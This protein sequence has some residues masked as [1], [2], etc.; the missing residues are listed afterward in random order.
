MGHHHVGREEK[1][2]SFLH[3]VHLVVDGHVQTPFQAEDNLDALD[4]DLD[5]AEIR[6]L[7]NIVHQEDI[8][9]HEFHPIAGLEVLY[10]DF[11]HQ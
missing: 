9:S 3:G 7:G 6:H 4:L 2:L 10:A 5:A 11:S 8:F 1:N